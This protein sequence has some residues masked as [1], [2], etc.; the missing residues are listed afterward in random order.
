MPLLGWIMPKLHRV[1]LSGCCQAVTFFV[2]TRGYARPCSSLG[3]RWRYANP[4]TTGLLSLFSAGDYLFP[5]L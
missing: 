2:L 1:H 3:C 5:D 4:I